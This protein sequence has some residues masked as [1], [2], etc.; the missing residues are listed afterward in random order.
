MR[1]KKKRKIS[2]RKERIRSYKGILNALT[3]A[4]KD[5]MQGTAIQ[6][7]NKMR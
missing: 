5:I 6:S 2:L 3:T 7:P 1:L 4:N